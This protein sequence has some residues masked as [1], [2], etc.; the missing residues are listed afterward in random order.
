[1]P[2]STWKNIETFV[3]IVV[4]TGAQSLLD[5]GVGNGKWGFLFREYADVWSERFLKTQWKTTVDGIEIYEP[6]VQ[7]HQ[8]AVYTNILVGD[9]VT[10]VP[11]LGSYDLIMAADVIEHIQKEKA[12]ALLEQLKAKARI[13]LVTSIPLGAEWLGPRPFENPHESHLSA[14]TSHDLIGLGFNY[15]NLMKAPDSRRK[16]GFFVYSQRPLKV[17]G[18]RKLRPWHKRF[19]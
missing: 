13:A 12:T 18:L 9:A 2:T 4:Q 5:I 16:I 8:R 7:D 14:W 19:V 17:D 10:L 1:M 6:Y 11:T 15:Y 3:A